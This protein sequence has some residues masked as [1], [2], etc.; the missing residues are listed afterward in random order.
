MSGGLFSGSLLLPAVY[1]SVQPGLSH[2]PLRHPFGVAFLSA[3]QDTCYRLFTPCPFLNGGLL[4]GNPGSDCLPWFPGS[5]PPP[6]QVLKVSSPRCAESHSLPSVLV[7]VSAGFFTRPI[8]HVLPGFPA[9]L[10]ESGWTRQPGCQRAR[11]SPLLMI[12]FYCGPAALSIPILQF[13]AVA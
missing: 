11:L 4:S 12:Y 9:P 7:F 13:L 3:H 1:P 8:A 5:N 10:P 6:E 2:P